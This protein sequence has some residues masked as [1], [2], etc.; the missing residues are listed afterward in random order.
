MSTRVSNSSSS[1]NPD[2]DVKIRT[3]SDGNVQ[4]LRSDPPT[5]V[6]DGRQ[7]VTTAGTR[8]NFSNVPC[9]RVDITALSSNTGIVVIGAITCVAAAGTRR[10]T[11]LVANQPYSIEIDN[12]NKLYIDS[13]VSGEGVSYTAYS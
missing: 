6:V 9:E 7:V 5:T 3:T 8:V 12:L 13:T 4:Y 10:G 2:Y 11:P 1:I